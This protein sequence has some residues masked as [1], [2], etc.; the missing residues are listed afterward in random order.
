MIPTKTNP[1]ETERDTFARWLSDGETWIGVF[2]NH[3]LSHPDRGRRVALAF[4]NATKGEAKVG[5][6]RA[7]DHRTIGLGWRYLLVAICTTP[8][9]ALAALAAEGVK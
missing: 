3:D 4:D 2:E 5:T 9:E 1:S 7:P 6:S 8:E